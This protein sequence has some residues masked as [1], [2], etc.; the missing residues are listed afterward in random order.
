MV[1]YSDNGGAPGDELYNSGALVPTSDPSDT[2]LDLNLSES[3][4]LGSGDYWI[5]V[6]VNL[7]FNPDFTQWFWSTQSVIVGAE[8]FF[9]DEGDL[10]GA[11][12]V[13]WTA[14]SLALGGTASDQ[15]FQLFGV[16]ENGA[17]AAGDAMEINPTELKQDLDGYAIWPNPSKDMFN[18][19]F[20][21]TGQENAVLLIHNING[22]LVYRNDQIETGRS[23]LWNAAAY[24]Q[25]IYLIH[26]ITSESRQTFKV[27][28]Q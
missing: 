15:V 11:G 1:V 24:P 21:D 25:G 19:R 7:A 10:F 23:L 3:V 4:V 27:L 6:Y 5:S 20:K 17:V 13:D 8:G 9:K 2:N 16:V 26:M 28:K 14:A 18:F 12:A 22:R